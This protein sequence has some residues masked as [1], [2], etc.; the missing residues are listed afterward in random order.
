MYKAIKILLFTNSFVLFAGFMLGPIYAIF[1]E[2]IGGDLLDAGLTTG[3]FD[4][5]AGITT[6]VAGRFTDRMKESELMVVAGYI[7]MGGGFLLYMLV[8]SIWMLFVVQAIIGFAEAFYSPAF[9]AI[10]S[11]HL[12]R[13]RAATQWGMWESN[14]YFTAAIGAAAGGILATV[15]SFNVLFI[16]MA[17]LC[18]FSAVF[19][20]RLPREVL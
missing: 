9:N 18:F 3:I 7:I 4:V 6:L 16:V 17:A 20:W 13:E 15:F 11:K 5:A 19:I 14:N 8:D 10:Y 2:D 12:S 1:V